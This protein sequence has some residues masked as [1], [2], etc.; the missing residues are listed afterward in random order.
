MSTQTTKSSL[1]VLAV[2]MIIAIFLSFSSCAEKTK[3]QKEE[4]A[5]SKPE[6]VKQ[7]L[8][9]VKQHTDGFSY[10]FTTDLTRVAYVVNEGRSQRVF[11]NEEGGT[12]YDQVV[13]I[14]LTF[15]P[16]GKHYAY[17]ARS[18]KKWYV[19]RDGVPGGPYDGIQESA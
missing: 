7:F 19:V 3:P 4:P 5:K 16:D 6:R 9:S 11:I 14:S 15:S 10:T 13:P 2:M 12:L 1:T 17:W 18:G 8:F